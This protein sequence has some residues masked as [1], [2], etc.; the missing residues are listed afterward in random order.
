MVFLVCYCVMFCMFDG[1][2]VYVLLLCCVDVLMIDDVCV[3][4]CFDG[5]V[6]VLGVVWCDVCGNLMVLLC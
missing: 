2:L 1:Y 3:V 4:K 5:F 6:D